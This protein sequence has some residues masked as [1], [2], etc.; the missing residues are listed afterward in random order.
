MA[1]PRLRLDRCRFC[2]RELI[3]RPFSQQVDR[4]QE[5]GVGLET[6]VRSLLCRRAAAARN[7]VQQTYERRGRRGRGL[8]GARPRVALNTGTRGEIQ[9]ERLAW[10]VSFGARYLS[11]SYLID[12][13]YVRLVCLFICLLACLFTYGKSGLRKSSRWRTIQER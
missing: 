5:R 7:R 4:H 12:K 2:F 6:P 1:T 11:K 3:T 8:Q 10:P 9:Q 13:P